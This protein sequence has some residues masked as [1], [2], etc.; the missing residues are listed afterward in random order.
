MKME[1]EENMSNVVSLVDTS[2]MNAIRTQQPQ[3]TAHSGL[4]IA[5]ERELLIAL[6]SAT[7]G[8]AGLVVVVP[9]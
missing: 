6:P 4:A 9:L 2:L 1:I 5:L 7:L 8:R 3:S